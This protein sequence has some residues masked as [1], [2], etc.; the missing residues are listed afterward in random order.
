MVRRSMLALVLT[1]TLA[2]CSF[3]GDAFGMQEDFE[4]E[5]EEDF[6]EDEEEN[7]DDDVADDDDLDDVDEVDLDDDDADHADHDD[8]DEDDDDESFTLTYSSNRMP[9]PLYFQMPDLPTGCEVTA[10][11]MALGAEGFDVNPVTLA[12]KY[13]RYHQTDMAKGFVG[14]PF[15]EDGGG[16][17]P[18]A[19]ANSANDYLSAMESDLEATNIS[20]STLEELLEYVGQG[21]PA[22]V[23]VTL[24]YEDPIWVDDG[25]EVD[26]FSYQWYSN[27]HCIAIKGYDLDDNLILI[28][29]PSEGWVEKDLD[30]F[31]ELYDEIGRYA[32]VIG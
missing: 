13:L 2:V 30:E 17:F 5:W 22:V 11:T 10:L 26:G 16:I 14:N 3:A 25:S 1:G 6:E 21:C 18:P 12:K 29:D 31:K 32:I 27:E 23:W 28:G 4:E 9:M 19:L 8:A 24:Y 7:E 20:G 15:Q